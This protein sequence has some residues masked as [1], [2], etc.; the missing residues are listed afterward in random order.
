[1]TS[2]I[3]YQYRVQVT[4]S[5]TSKLYITDSSTGVYL[6]INPRIT[7]SGSA[8]IAGVYGNQVTGTYTTALGT[9][10][11]KLTLQ[12]GIIG[13]VLDTT[14]ATGGVTTT[15]FN[16]ESYANIV[17]TQ[18]DGKIIVGGISNPTDGRQLFAIARYLSTGVLDSTFGTGGIVTTDIPGGATGQTADGA[19]LTSLAIDPTSQKII[20]IGS[21][22]TSNRTYGQQVIAR[23]TTSGALDTTFN[24]TGYETFTMSSQ[25]LA[26]SLFFDITIQNDGKY[27][28]AG[29]SQSATAVFPMAVILRM[30]TDGT[31]DTSF[32]KNGYAQATYVGNINSDYQTISYQSD[33]KIIAAG[34]TYTG[35]R[36]VYHTTRYT[37]TGAID[38]S[39][40]TNG[41]YMSA[42]PNNAGLAY[43]PMPPTYGSRMIELKVAFDDSI[44]FGF[45][46]FGSNSSAYTSHLTKSGALDTTYGSSGFTQTPDST[47]WSN[48][49]GGIALAPNGNVVL[50]ATFQDSNDS[51]MGYPT[52]VVEWSSTGQIINTFGV[53]G[54]V[55]ETTTT[56]VINSA[57]GITTADNGD[58]YVVGE[59]NIN[60]NGRWK[61]FKVIGNT[62]QNAVLDSRITIDTSTTDQININVAATLPAGVYVLNVVSTDSVTAVTQ[63]TVNLRVGRAAAPV[64]TAYTQP[65]GLWTVTDT[66]IALVETSTV[67]GLVNNDTITLSYT[68]SST[69]YGT[70][71]GTP[72]WV[73]TY[74]I[75]PKAIAV[76]NG[77]AR[78]GV[79]SNYLAPTYNTGT[80]HVNPGNRNFL[81]G[82]TLDAKNFYGDSNETITLRTTG[83]FGNDT[84]T[85]TFALVA[86]GN[87]A[88][89]LVTTT[90][91]LTA[92]SPGTCQVTAS[93]AA[94]TQH[95]A[96]Q[97]TA[98]ITFTNL[99][100]H[101]FDLTQQ[102]IGGSHTLLL[103]QQYGLVIVP[104]Y[105]APDSSTTTYAPTITSET[106]TAGNG[107]STTT[108]ILIYGTNFW[109][110]TGGTSVW[111]GRNLSFRDASSYLTP[112]SSTQ[113]TLSLPASFFTNNGF[114]A[115]N[116]M[117]R[118]TVT[119]PSGSVTYGPVTLLNITP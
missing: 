112:N 115:G 77:Y 107:A 57:L 74:T 86:A 23:Y 68:Y 15:T 10:T 89:C 109:T 94:S 12:P 96:A 98:T 116:S 54:T 55:Y 36:Y 69:Q 63:K 73:D 22:K 108:T 40:A 6:Y 72:I 47:I 61:L 118:I 42:A 65:Y 33:G 20:A 44:Y 83:L 106:Q 43:L 99:L 102:N 46:G 1:M 7:I 48:G 60:T 56:G 81:I 50:A 80:V 95:L 49:F 92:A 41:Y 13:G 31:I 117:G 37:T 82:T 51:P 21:M 26:S 27:L 53:N 25:D 71:T 70:L 78:Y 9:G 45:L 101:Y 29:D 113:L 3:Q 8:T 85:A 97:D 114:T 59:Q 91:V 38:T 103:Q 111:I 35:G 100:S 62:L 14:F 75:T 67:T 52:D 104:V 24:G 110:T 79:L 64:I 17:R 4:D 39:F 5:D 34:Q 11:R 84:T 119:T 32:A 30:N 105:V 28:L 2:G 18:S 76:S 93:I 88:G 90:G 19:H 58:I 66:N 16:S 87:N